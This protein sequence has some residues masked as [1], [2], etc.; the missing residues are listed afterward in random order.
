MTDLVIGDIGLLTTQETD[1]DVCEAW[2]TEGDVTCDTSSFEPGV[3]DRALLDAS[4]V[5]F[6]LSG[7]QF[8]GICEAVVRPAGQCSCGGGCSSLREIGLGVTPIVEVTE[9]KV[10]GE[11]LESSAYRVDN[12]ATLVRLRDEDQSR[13]SWPCCPIMDLDSDEEGTFEVSF[14]YGRRPPSMGVDAAAKLACEI[15]KSMSGQNC[16]LPERVTNV[17]RQGVSVSVVAPEDFL[18]S[19]R[20]G[21]FIV[22][23]FLESVNPHSLRRPPGIMSPDIPS[24][25][26]AGT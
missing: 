13:A 14:T 22:D 9:V 15:A 21:I 19:G 1:S 12:Q 26:R 5:L 16:A 4:D 2:A 3:L 10:D 17:T 6:H 23:M 11:V 8:P 24:S 25:R 18:D 20:T 7:R